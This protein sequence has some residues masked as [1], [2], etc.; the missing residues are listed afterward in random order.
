MEKVVNR[1]VLGT[2][3][4]VIA[5]FLNPLG[6]DILVYKLTI[7][8]NDYWTTMRILYAFAALFFGLSFLSFKCDNRKQGNLFLVIAMFL[9]PL[10]F[11]ILFAFT[12]YFIK[13]YVLTTIVFY[14]GTI[15]F[16]M[17]YLHLY[18]IKLKTGVKMVFTNFGTNIRKL[19]KK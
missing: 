6:F 3:C 14:L 7:L 11:D 9:N 4:L 2:V 5:T 12:N 13:S 8:T 17:L 10:G 18:N 19:I 16:F 15:F 1:K